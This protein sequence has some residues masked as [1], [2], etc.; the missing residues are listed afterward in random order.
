MTADKPFASYEKKVVRQYTV[1]RHTVNIRVGASA[2]DVITSLKMV[3]PGA[4]IQFMMEEDADILAGS[5][6]FIEEEITP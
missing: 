1:V 6:L 5:L 2:V 3:P 4:K